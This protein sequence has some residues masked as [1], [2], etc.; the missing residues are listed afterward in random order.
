MNIPAPIGVPA[1]IYH[2]F[3]L[4]ALRLYAQGFRKFSA[5]A[6][7]H[8]MRWQARVER[9][10]HKYEVNNNW[11]ALMARHFM[12][13]YPLLKGFFETRTALVDRTNILQL[14]AA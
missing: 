7:V 3:E 10:N 1:S 6:I 4:T 8:Q 2:E 14:H 5:R 9:G 11:T 12:K 13:R